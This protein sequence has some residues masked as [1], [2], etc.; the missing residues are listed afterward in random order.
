MTITEYALF[1]SFFI[2]TFGI[3]TIKLAEGHLK[4]RDVINAALFGFFGWLIAFVRIIPI[5]IYQIIVLSL[6]GVNYLDRQELLNSP[7]IY[8]Y[9][10]NIIGPLLSGLFEEPIRY[11]FLREAVRT[12]DQPSRKRAT[13]IFGLAW[14][15]A[16]IA[17]LSLDILSENTIPF[18][19]LLLSGYERIVATIF[20]VALSRFSLYL[21]NFNF[22][23]GIFEAIAVHDS[24]NLIALVM[25]LELQDNPLQLYIIEGVFTVIVI[26]YIVYL[27]FRLPRQPPRQDL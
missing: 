24:V 21:I 19:S 7:V 25:L 14:A 5:Q 10:F 22:K 15:Y 27:H 2:I 4:K 13:I 23:K 1:Q 18:S 26:A 17:I 11:F 6:N 20:H 16:E 9:Q 8:S 3:L 12:I